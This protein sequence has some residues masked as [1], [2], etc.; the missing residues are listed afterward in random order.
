[1]NRQRSAYIF[2]F[3]GVLVDSMEAHFACY[4]RALEEAGVPVD[5]ERFYYQA[6][7]TGREQI[8]YFAEKAGVEVDVERVYQR[9]RQLKP[10]HT[11]RVKPIE[12]NIQLLNALRKAGHPVAIASGSTKL[13]IMP[14]V[15][16]FGIEADAIV[17]ADDVARGKPHPDL[18]LEAAARLGV[19]PANCTVVEDAEVGVQ[20]A[21]NAGM[22]VMR[23]FHN[24]SRESGP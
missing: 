16:R 10:E 13:S 14:V 7:M 21:R 3:D 5:K 18:F 12:A 8:K 19:T 20:A 24:T 9:N 1:M 15:E 22:K 17:A 2:D 11:H 6:G 23:F 4:K